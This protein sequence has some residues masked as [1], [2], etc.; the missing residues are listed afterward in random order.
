MTRRHNGLTTAGLVLAA[1]M[2]T[3]CSEGGKKPVAKAHESTPP[4][5]AKPAELEFG[6]VSAPPTTVA[7]G[8][9]TFADGE[10]A[11][12]AKNYAEAT[13]IFALYTEQRPKNAWGHYMLGLSSWK[14]GDL[15]G[16]EKAF[17][18]A[19]RI[20]PKHVKSLVNFSRVLL[21]Q[22]RAEDALDK[23]VLAGELDPASKDVPRLLGRAYSAKGDSVEAI[24]AYRH[25]IEIDGKDS[26]AMNNLGLI[27]LEQGRAEDA[28][29]L[30][31]RAVELGK[32]VPAFHNNLGMALEHTGRFS[33]A[34]T[35][36]SNAVAADPNYEKA[37]QN[38]ARVEKVK[39]DPK[40]PFEPETTAEGPAEKID[41]KT[42]E[43]VETGRT[44]PIAS[45]QAK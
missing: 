44:E 24:K 35:A 6:E 9:V 18:E 36:Y 30:L 10:A 26:W 39:E 32:D 21:D 3:A 5:S 22:N 8:P 25:A 45:Q 14:G 7:T 43:K 12:Q 1:G 4:V 2:A 19:L 40:E 13:R 29:P 42:E 17:D 16:A 11:F 23:L 38:L 27:L 28:L 41:D 34:A 20:D 37:K 33:A 31:A 15:V